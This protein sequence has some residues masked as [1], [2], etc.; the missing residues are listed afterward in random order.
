MHACTGVIA[1]SGRGCTPKQKQEPAASG[2]VLMRVILVL[3]RAINLN[4]KVRFTIGPKSS[5]VT[6]FWTS[7]HGR[8]SF[9][10]LDSESTSSAKALQE[11][12][13]E[14]EVGGKC[15]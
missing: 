3:M 2:F 9:G 10:I 8:P 5:P 13:K 14:K 4:H 12:K 1:D 6:V 7:V 11:P 15:L